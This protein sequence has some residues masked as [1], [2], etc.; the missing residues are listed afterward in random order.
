MSKKASKRAARDALRNSF[1][2]GKYWSIVMIKLHRFAPLAFLFPVLFGSCDSLRLPFGLGESTTAVLWTDRPEFAV[3]VE[4]FNAGQDRYKIEVRYFA[5]PAQKLTDNGEYPD[6]AAGSWLKSAST[7]TL[8]RPLDALFKDSLDPAAFYPRLLALGRIDD[9]Q[10]LLPVSF[11]LPALVFSRETG[12]LLS[13]Q[14]VIGL[15][16]IKSA[17]KAYNLET[18]GAFSRMGFSPAWDNEFLFVTAMLFKASFR[19]AAP[20]AWDA[21]ALNRAV[22]YIRQWIEEAN[23]GIKAEDDFVFKYFFDPPAKLVTGGRILFTYMDSSAFFTQREE[24]LSN[25]DLRWISEGDAIP[26]SED[27]TFIGICKDGKA[28]K[29][30][31]AFTQWFFQEETQRAFLEKTRAYRLNETSYGIA[32]GFSA[33]RT[34]TENVFPQYYP[35]LLG[36]M[37]PEAFLSPPNI[38]PRN[39][40]A[41]KERVIL[42]YLHDRIRSAFPDTARSLERRLTDWYRINQGS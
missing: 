20:L 30:A 9:K 23:T 37:P 31:M 1:F 35:R 18:E 11:N 15:E 17:G 33:L 29:A 38:L 27:M 6:I 13:N 7:R 16:E 34:V 12:D 5:S 39:W 21:N 40:T 41:I 8:F 3:Y 24:Q 4:D 42:P 25:L 28:Q 22:L 14:F 26:L 10:Y 36:R 32:N 19:E 2:H